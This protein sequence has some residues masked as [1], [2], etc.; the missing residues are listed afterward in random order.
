M[1]LLLKMIEMDCQEGL[2]QVVMLI[3]QHQR[4]ELK[5]LLIHTMNAS[6]G[7]K[8]K[9]FCPILFV[10]SILLAPFC[11]IFKRIANSNQLRDLVSLSKLLFEVQ[12][13]TIPSTNW[14]TVSIKSPQ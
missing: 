9:F 1:V 11:F 7:L 4:A 8:S 3:N 10:F 12:L 13:C 14:K 6:Q 2:S 5:I